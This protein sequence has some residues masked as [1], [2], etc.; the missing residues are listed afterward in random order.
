MLLQEKLEE[1]DK[2]ILIGSIFV[3]SA[4]EDV[5]PSQWLLYNFEDTGGWCSIPSI[6]L[7]VKVQDTVIWQA[8]STSV[9]LPLPM[10]EDDV[11]GAILK[12]NFQKEYDVAP[13]VAMWDSWFYRRWKE[14]RSMMHPLAENWQHLL[15]IFRKFGLRWWKHRQ[16]RS[17]ISFGKIYQSSS[18]ITHKT[19][20]KVQS[21]SDINQYGGVNTQKL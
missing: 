9:P 11:V 19:W 6:Y 10:M 15:G 7:K 20:I 1:L 16:L 17:W 21:I 14:N 2:K 5:A 12:A 18:H 13:P 4:G 8:L 3:I